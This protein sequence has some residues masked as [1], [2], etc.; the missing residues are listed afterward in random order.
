MVDVDSP[1]PL[2]GTEGDTIGRDPTDRGSRGLGEASWMDERGEPLSVVVVGANVHDTRL[3]TAALAHIVVERPCP[4][5]RVPQPL[6]VDKSC[7]NPTQQRHTTALRRRYDA[8][9]TASAPKPGDPGDGCG[10]GSPP[11]SP[12]R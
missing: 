4:R 9:A 12:V 2:K 3:W 1:A 7:D 5:A 11:A 8:S 6:C 10:A